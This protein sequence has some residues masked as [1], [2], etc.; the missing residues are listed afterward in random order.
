MSDVT[1]NAGLGLQSVVNAATKSAIPPQQIVVDAATNVK[2]GVNFALNSDV[3]NALADTANVDQQQE[4]Q[5][6]L[7]QVASSLTETMSM[8][9]KGLEFK[10]DEL[11]GLPVVSVVDVNSGE[12]IRQIPSEE[13]LALAEKMS[14][15]AGVLM[16]TEA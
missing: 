15:I 10:V 14:E 7:T 16:K 5:T 2:N 12:L 9:K 8:M 11:E 13:A 4:E 1:L 3:V 6:S